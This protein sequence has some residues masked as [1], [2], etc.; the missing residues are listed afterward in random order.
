MRI[1]CLFFAKSGEVTGVGEKEYDLSDG[2]DTQELL[3]KVVEEY[4]GLAKVLTTAILSIN[5]EY[6]PLDP[7]TT[8]NE[9]DEI[10]IIPPISGG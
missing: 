7:P 9:G 4:P 8:L 2:A 6:T 5:L 3:C 1:K 10:A